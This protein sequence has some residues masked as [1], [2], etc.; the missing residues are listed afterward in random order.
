MK[1]PLLLT[2]ILTCL[3]NYN[4]RAQDTAAFKKGTIVITAGVGVPDYY[5]ASLRTAYRG[6]SSLDVFGYGPIIIKGDYGIVKFKWGHSVGAGIVLGYSSSTVKYSDLS[7]SNAI[8]N[9]YHGMDIYRTITIGARGTYH[10][11]TKKD[12]D[13]YASIGLG[14]NINTVSQTANNGYGSTAYINS[15]APFRSL[16]YSAFTAGVR[17][18]FNKNIGVYGEG[19]WDMSTIIQGGIAIKF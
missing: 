16:S 18:Y 6:H 14:I 12:L 15:H 7:T 8:P 5:R 9:S 4:Y 2:L 17:Y 11:F 1:T 19:G 13:C 10:F 3:F